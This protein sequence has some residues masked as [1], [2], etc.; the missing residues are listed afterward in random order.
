MERPAAAASMDDEQK[1]EALPIVRMNGVAR[2]PAL[3]PVAK[4]QPLT[5]FL[6]D[7]ELVT[8]LCTPS[9]LKYLA[10]GF[11][12]SEGIIQTRE[13][14][15]S[16]VVDEPRGMAWVKTGGDKEFVRELVSKRLVTSGCGAG[17]TFYRIGDKVRCSMVTSRASFPPGDISRLMREVQHMAGV[18][19]STGGVHSA[20]LSDGER[21]L[22]FCDDIGRH[23]AVDKVFGKCLLEGIEV[24]DRLIVT[25]GRVSSEV[26]LKVAVRSVPVI[27]SRAAPTVLAVRLADQLGVT[28]VGFARGA[29]MNI[30]THEGR[31]ADTG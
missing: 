6:D 2:E 3:D 16:L 23:N 21:V 24:K 25:S 28:L 11:L 30:Y 4:E 14:I 9:D 10:A 31:V 17:A 26:L 27:V 1:A 18:Y 7:E 19:R 20:A 29:R 12:F 8:L 13:D 22:A 5:I 15:H